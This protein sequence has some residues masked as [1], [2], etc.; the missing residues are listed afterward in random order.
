MLLIKNYLQ[1]W[2]KKRKVDRSGDMVN[3]KEASGIVV[4]RI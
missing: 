4:G 3:K 2:I 1:R